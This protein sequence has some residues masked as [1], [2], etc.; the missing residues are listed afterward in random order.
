M[1]DIHT[2]ILPMID[3]GPTMVQESL[4]MCRIAVND[5]INKIIAT[6]HVQNGMYDLDANKVLEKV[7]MLNQLIKQE[8]LDL[9]IFPGA[10]V[11]LND[12]L[13][14]A[15]ILR[16]SSILT[17]NGGKKYILLE[18]P[19]QWVPPETEQIIFK[20]KLMGLTPV[21]PHLERNYRIQRNPHMVVRY[22]E[23]GAILQVTAQSIVGDFD[24]APLKCVLWMLKNNLVHVIASDAH[25]PVA[26]PPI[27][28]RAVK[29]VSDMLGEEAARKMVLENPG[30]ILEGLPFNK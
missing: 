14:D 30:T 20:L 10:E 3:D 22:V 8:G 17:I 15:E 4:E 6:P 16:E 18:F 19:F 29:I 25:S 1:I 27:L 26:R 7:D 21:L 13:L 5:G 2:H 23:M 12:R 9:V 28:S 11:H 24:A